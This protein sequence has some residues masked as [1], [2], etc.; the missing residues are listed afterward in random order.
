MQKRKCKNERRNTEMDIGHLLNSLVD[1][2]KWIGP[3]M[4]VDKVKALIG[5]NSI[6]SCKTKS[7]NKK[8]S[9]VGS[10][11]LEPSYSF[12]VFSKCYNSIYVMHLNESLCVESPS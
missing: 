10:F 5:L 8:T 12:Y 9:C 7:H 3:S 4:H 1:D 11:E 6:V 2:F